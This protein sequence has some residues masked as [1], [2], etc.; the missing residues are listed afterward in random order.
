MG[1]NSVLH[2]AQFCQ[3]S[4]RRHCLSRW[5]VAVFRWR[6]CCLRQSSE[7]HT[8]RLLPINHVWQTGQQWNRRLPIFTPCRCR[9]TH[10]WSASVSGPVWSCGHL[11]IS[12]WPSGPSGGILILPSM[13]CTRKATNSPSQ[14]SSRSRTCR[15]TGRNGPARST[16]SSKASL[17]RS[18][19]GETSR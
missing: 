9:G 1:V 13:A 11:A 18:I 3:R 2:W 5:T 16:D 6:R 17:W 12:L 19:A 10:Q 4:S 7:Q 8:A 15:S 14:N